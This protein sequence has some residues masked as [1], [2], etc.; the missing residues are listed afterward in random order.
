[1]V[2]G[3]FNL[4]L[5]LQLCEMR[6]QQKGNQFADP[7]AFTKQ[8]L[9]RRDPRGFD[10]PKEESGGQKTYK[11]CAH[12]SSDD[13]WEVEATYGLDSEL[14]AGLRINYDWRRSDWVKIP[15]KVFEA[16]IVAMGCGDYAHIFKRVPGRQCELWALNIAALQWKKVRHFTED[17]TEYGDVDAKVNAAGET[18]VAAFDEEGSG[19]SYSDVEEDDECRN[20]IRVWDGMQSPRTIRCDELHGT[21]SQL[22]FVTWDVLLVSTVK[23]GSEDVGELGLYYVGLDGPPRMIARTW[24]VAKRYSPVFWV[25][26]C[27]HFIHFDKKLLHPPTQELKLI[28]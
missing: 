24:W 22:C 26:R 10:A 4:A 19:A 14:P 5:E 23:D 20:W 27:G 8:F 17:L 25:S 13:L 21:L 2:N 3:T 16:F 6:F 1:M 18:R 28:F 7:C 12:Q 11:C 9:G 15:A